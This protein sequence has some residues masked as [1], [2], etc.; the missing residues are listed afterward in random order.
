MNSAYFHK[1][2]FR[3]CDVPAPDGYPQSQTHAGVAAWGDYLLLSTSPYPEERN[4]RKRAIKKL[5]RILTK[6]KQGQLING[7][8]Y[9]NPCLYYGQVTESG[10]PTKFLPLYNNPLMPTPS[11]YLGTPSFNSD[12]QD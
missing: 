9:E 6:N 10:Y 5:L 7:E 8:Y 2:D 1:K 11:P 12:P 3:P 4:M